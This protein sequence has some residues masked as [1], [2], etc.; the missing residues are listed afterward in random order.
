MKQIKLTTLLFGLL[1][2]SCNQTVTSGEGQNQT[3]VLKENTKSKT[4][5]IVT[6]SISNE[7]YHTKYEYTDSIGNY[8]IIQNSFPRGELYTDPKGN[9]YAKA[10][11]WTRIINET[12]NPFELTI[13]FSGDSYEFPGSVGS[14]VSSYYKI[15]VP[16]D[17]MT[18]DKERIYNYNLTELKSFLEV[19][20]GKPSSLKRTIHP[21]ESSGFYV[22]RLL[23]KPKSG[24]QKVKDDGNGTT[25]AGFSLKGQNIIYRLNGKEI[26]CGKVNLKNLVLKNQLT[27]GI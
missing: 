26:H 19:S 25:R 17:T 10:I 18:P 2:F 11:F 9:E 5:D 7:T 6:S 21:N 13:D 12:D 20:I 3:N 22:V 1:L 4:Q 14:S 15:L 16:P 27:T 24:W 8:L 23:I